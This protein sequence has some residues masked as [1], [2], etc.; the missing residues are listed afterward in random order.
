MEKIKKI[1]C[2]CCAYLTKK[3]EIKHSFQNLINSVPE[4]Y[5]IQKVQGSDTGKSSL[6]ELY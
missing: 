5:Y 4:E 1:L 3:Q 2:L 6:S